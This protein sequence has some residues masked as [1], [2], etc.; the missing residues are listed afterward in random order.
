[1]LIEG[2][3]GPEGPAVSKQC[4]KRT[5]FILEKFH[6][7]VILFYCHCICNFVLLS[8][9]AILSLLGNYWSKYH[10]DIPLQ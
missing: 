4:S 5:C 7:N 10:Q 8:K 6:S 9:V 3:P 1:M 2:P